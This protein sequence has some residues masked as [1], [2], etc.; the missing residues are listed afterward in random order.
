MSESIENAGPPRTLEESAQP[1]EPLKARDHAEPHHPGPRKYIQIGIWLALITVFEVAVYYVDFF[2]DREPLLVFTLVTCMFIKFMIVAR[3]F[4][5]LKFDN[6]GY[7]RV[8]A[9]GIALA[10]AVYVVVLATFGVFT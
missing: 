9:T 5:H 2:T 1:G 10:V 4:M 8:F 7:G 6:P 3:W